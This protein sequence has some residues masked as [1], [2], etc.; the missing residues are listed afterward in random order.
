M[1]FE[2]SG[3]PQQIGPAFARLDALAR[4]QGVELLLAPDEAAK[5]GLPASDGGLEGASSRSSS[6]ATARCCVR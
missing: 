2:R 1:G 3:K 5:H 6:A 4:E